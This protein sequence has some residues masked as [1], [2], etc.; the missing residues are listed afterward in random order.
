MASIKNFTPRIYQQTIMSECVKMN[1]LVVL[2]TGLG[3]TAI[4]LMLCV[5]RL[6]NFPKSKILFLAPT[7]PLVQQHYETFKRHLDLTDEGFAVFTGEINPDK[8][9]VLWKTSR[10]VFS[11]P[12]GIE[13]D[14]LSGRINL[15]DV[16][17]LIFDEAHRT[18]GNYAYA[19]V[20]QQYEKRARFFKILGL[21]ASPGSDMEKISEVC[22]NLYIDHIEVRSDSDYDVKQYIQEVNIIWHEVDFPEELKRIRNYLE[23]CIKIRLDKL[24]EKGFVHKGQFNFTKK[25]LIDI[26]KML[27]FSVAR[28]EKDFENLRAL[29]VFAEIM[30]V[31]HAVELVETQGV[32]ALLRYLEKI[33]AEAPNSSV[34]AVQNIVRDENFKSAYFLCRKFYDEGIEHPKMGELKNIVSSEIRRVEDAKIIVFNQFRDN[35]VKIFDELSKLENVRPA[36]FV[37]QAKKGGTGTSQKKQKDILDKFASGIFNVL[38]STSVGEEGLDIPKVDT[39]VFYEPVPSAIRHI[40]RKGRTGRL[41]KGKVIILATRGTRDIGYKWS[42]HSKEKKMYRILKDLK[43]KLVISLQRDGKKEQTFL[44]IEA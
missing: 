2:P 30:K 17:L 11:T 5:H 9:A 23:L 19:F 15:E 24:K 12:Q 1:T 22:R 35:V 41:E 21:T 38:I 34:K 29:S 27:H 8:R 36:I 14:I 43:K 31:L 6:N 4:A 26:Q 28:G 32:T 25:E 16:S 44:N 20:A 40:Q 33:F 39:V 18:V 10:I 7:K 3:K 13:N 42:A 37:G